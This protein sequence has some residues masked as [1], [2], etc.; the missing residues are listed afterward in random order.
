MNESAFTSI[1]TGLWITWCHGALENP[2][3]PASSSRTIVASNRTN[4]VTL[5]IYNGDGGLSMNGHLR[6]QKAFNHEPKMSD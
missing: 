2:K 3:V 1:Q 5:R 6:G 4:L